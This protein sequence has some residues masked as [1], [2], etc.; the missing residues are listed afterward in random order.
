M[1]RA[2]GGQRYLKE[3][4]GILMDELHGVVQFD[5]IGVSLRDQ[6]SDKFQS[7]FIDMAS[8]SE[9]VPEGQLMPEETL[10]LWVY[11][12]QEPLLMSTGEM[13]PRYGGLQA[14]L[15]R[16][17]IRSTCA[18]PL[19]TA[20]RKLGG[21]TFCSKEV[22]TYSANDIGFVSQV[23]DYIALA[24]DDALN[25]AALRRASE[26][27][28]SK[29]D[30]LRLLLDVTNQVVSNLELRDLLRSISHAVLPLIQYDY[31]R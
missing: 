27:L 20:H 22:D 10:T 2:M 24:F 31:A 9:L 6:D 1:S 11:E 18:L 25:F 8:R 23:A 14:V 21:I 4:F 28:Q 17:N 3:L 7:Y 12:Q 13:E 30:R 15:K 5:F 26:E 16:L 19:T 29:N